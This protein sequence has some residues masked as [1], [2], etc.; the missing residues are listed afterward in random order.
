MWV[1]R[2]ERIEESMAVWDERAFVRAS[3]KTE[4]KR[5]YPDRLRVRETEMHVGIPI[6]NLRDPPD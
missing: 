4:S 6:P 2:F 5:K 1:P 3:V